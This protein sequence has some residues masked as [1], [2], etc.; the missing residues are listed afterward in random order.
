MKPK[1]Q[2]PQNKKKNKAITNSLEF[3]NILN[4][5]KKK[6]ENNKKNV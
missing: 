5:E 2:I 4:I 6:E 1:T 3:N